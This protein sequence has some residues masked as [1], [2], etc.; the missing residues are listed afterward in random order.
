VF[1]ASG[2]VV[3]DV[4][5]VEVE[6]LLVVADDAFDSV[7]LLLV[8][9]DLLRYH[10]HGLGQTVHRLFELACIR[11]PVF[12]PKLQRTVDFDHI[13]VQLNFGLVVLAKV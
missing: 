4:E 7:E 5:Y 11:H 3:E 10:V 13:F 8:V 1:D 9:S 12:V 6:F 2:G